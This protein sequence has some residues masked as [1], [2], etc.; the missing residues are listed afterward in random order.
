VP[1]WRCG[2]SLAGD[3]YVR[4]VSQVAGQVD[5]PLALLRT[6]GFFRVSQLVPD[7]QDVVTIA[8]GAKVGNALDLMRERG[9][10]QLPVTTVGGRVVGA[11]TY[12]SFAHGVRFIRKQDDPLAAPVDDLVEDLQ[13]VRP[14]QDVSDILGFLDADNVVLVGDEDRLLAIVTCADV[15]R[16]LWERTRPF[17]LLRDIELGVRDLMRSS[18]T[19]QRIA[20]LISAGLP[21]ES[22]RN[23]LR[24]EDLRLSEL[25]S[26]LLQPESFGKFFQVGFGA[27]REL[28]R[29]T[30]TPVVEIRNKE[31]HFRDEVSGD[32]V[33]ALVNV[34]TWLRRKVMIRDGGR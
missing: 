1:G 13:F 3:W 24:L 31:F 10:D 19:A 32:E 6:P 9:F 23:G 22:V 34:A 18:C 2:P 14:S 8:V 16:F 30:L 17:V 5:V 12:R 33:Q 28:V 11:F 25:L 29:A 15:S 4:S 20:G 26:V 7:D 21:A 27:S